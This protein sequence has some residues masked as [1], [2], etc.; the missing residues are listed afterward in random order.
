MQNERMRLPTR[1]RRSADSDSSR[2]GFFWEE[3]GTVD[4]WDLRG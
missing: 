1:E 3:Q 4:I 2:E